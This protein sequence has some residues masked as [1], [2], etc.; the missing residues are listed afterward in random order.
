MF[1]PV[2]FNNGDSAGLGNSVLF[3]MTL[4]IPLLIILEDPSFISSSIFL[5]SGSSNHLVEMP[6]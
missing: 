5:I 3:N 6:G 2:D 4:V 1:Y